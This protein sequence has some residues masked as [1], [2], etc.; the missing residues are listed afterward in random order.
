MTTNLNLEL[1]KLPKELHSEINDR[2][3]LTVNGFIHFFKHMERVGMIFSVTK[4]NH[5]IIYEGTS[6]IKH[7]FPSI[8]KLHKELDFELMLAHENL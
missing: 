4:D 7:L 1:N 2:F 5:V 6:I 3:Y 8:D